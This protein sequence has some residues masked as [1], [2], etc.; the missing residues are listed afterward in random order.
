MR[1]N[2]LHIFTEASTVSGYGHVVRCQALA[3]QAE[4]EGIE[5][6]F[7]TPHLETQQ[8]LSAVNLMWR[9]GTS[10]VPRWVIRDMPG[11]NE[12]RDVT[13]AVEKGSIVLL[14]DEKGPARAHATIVIDAMMSDARA[15]SLPFADTTKYYYGLDYVVLRDEISKC[16]AV[17]RPGKNSHLV[18]ALG[19][20]FNEAFELDLLNAL[21]HSQNFSSADV[22]LMS[23]PSNIVYFKKIANQLNAELHIRQSEVGPILR[24]ADLVVTK[25]GMTQLEAFCCGVPC[26]VMEPGV[27]HLQVQLDLQLLYQPW[28]AQELGLASELDV[29]DVALRVV[30]QLSDKQNL[31]DMGRRAAE[32]VD[33]GGTERIISL[34]REA[35]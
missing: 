19:Q 2:Q 3:Q 9:S 8:Y 5:V 6:I 17:G 20:G 22:L 18:I 11:T 33:G 24:R 16:H 34:L 14:L 29:N 15:R 12:I 26:L 4:R 21:I 30:A 31:M 23:E 25:L 32:I 27:D 28:P 13:E 1:Q 7:I 10:D 35:A